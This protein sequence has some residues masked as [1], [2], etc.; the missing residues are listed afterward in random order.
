M[1]TKTLI[2]ITVAMT[3]LGMA[4]GASHTVGA[5]HGSW[6]LQTNY[7]Q[8]VSRIRFTT[9]D[10]LKFQY[11]AAVHNVVEVS[12]TGYDSCNGSSPIATFP[13]GNDVVPLATVGT[14]YFICG[15]SRHCDAGMKVEVNVKSKEVRTVQRC[16]R[17]GNRRRCQSETVLSSAAAAGVDQSTVAR[18]GLIVVAAGLT[19]FF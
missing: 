10:E 19:L 15:V 16:R 7:S 18:L 14:R 11:S 5:P 3:M 9:G 1:E 8:W 6:D 17:R 12:K 2:L 4:L 13:S